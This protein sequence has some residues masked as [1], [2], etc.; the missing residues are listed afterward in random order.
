MQ[1]R[2]SAVLAGCL[3]FAV[4]YSCVDNDRTLG[5][6][7]VS[8]DYLLKIRTAEFLL[9]VVQ[10][11]HDTV[12]ASNSSSMITG[13]LSDDTYGSFM[14]GGASLV[15]P[16]ADSAYLGVEPELKNVYMRLYI[17]S[18]VSYTGNA[19][20]MP[21]NIY[22]YEL[23][24]PIDSTSLFNNSITPDYLSEEPISLGSPMIFGPSSVTISL[25]K[26]Y[27]RKLLATTPDE[28]MDVNL[29]LKR[30]YGIYVKTD[31]PD[32]DMPGGRL[33]YLGLSS[34]IIYVEYKMNDPEM[35]IVDKDTVVTF[36]F[37]YGA[38]LNQY[39]CGSRHLSTE[40]PGDTLYMEGFSGIKPVIPADTLK[41]MLDEWKKKIY[42]ECGY[43]DRDSVQILLS[44]ATLHFP[45]EMPDDHERF[46]KDH[47]LT[48][49]PFMTD[50]TAYDSTA[51]FTPSDDLQYSGG[52][53][54]DR[55]HGEYYC[56]VTRL[57]QDFIA[58]DDVSHTDDMWICP[59]IT[60]TVTSYSYSYS[61]YDFD[62]LNYYRLI[63]NGPSSERPPYL[64]ITYSLFDY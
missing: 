18:C 38:A 11:A 44:R 19:A 49:F 50:V 12:Q 29:F 36:V 10:R 63:L 8:E 5:Q 52:G 48:I 1:N 62:A 43:D 2:L 24:K 47:P 28:F 57:M 27:G 64:T 34:S 60:E 21:Q 23:V 17:D 39:S 42:R 32:T 31:I 22:L 14:V 4:V 16:V 46:E 20:S 9:P 6:Q 7:F 25:T 33:N 51:V 40:K 45:Y 58:K 53:V 3:L 61:T 54:M 37:G 41:K 26:E 55:S 15:V 35:G 56:D 13:Y 30:L 59:V